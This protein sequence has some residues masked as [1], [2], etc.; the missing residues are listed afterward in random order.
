MLPMDF[1][2]GGY[3]NKKTGFSENPLGRG[4]VYFFDKNPG[5]VSRL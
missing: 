4:R 1:Y 3:H 2:R 5:V